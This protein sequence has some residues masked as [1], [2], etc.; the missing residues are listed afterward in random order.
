MSIVGLGA[1]P[2]PRSLYF[3]GVARTFCFVFYFSLPVWLYNKKAALWC[4]AFLSVLI[5][6]M[7]VFCTVLRL[8]WLVLWTHVV[9]RGCLRST[10]ATKRLTGI[11]PF[12]AFLVSRAVEISRG[13]LNGVAK[14]FTNSS[15]NR[16]FGRR[17]IAALVLLT[18]SSPS[19]IKLI[20]SCGA[21]QARRYNSSFIRGSFCGPWLFGVISFTLVSREL[22]CCQSGWLSCGPRFGW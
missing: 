2:C 11:I 20:R 16:V 12:S 18:V 4:A 10:R 9:R 21:S 7:F 13:F 14:P 19:V 22:V 8:V 5:L 6:L 1:L 15:W 17:W 3:S